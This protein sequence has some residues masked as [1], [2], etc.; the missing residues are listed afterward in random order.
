MNRCLF[1]NCD[2]IFNASTRR[3]TIKDKLRQ[4]YCKDCVERSFYDD[5]KIK[6]LDN[7]G[8]ADK[9]IERIYEFN[10]VFSEK[11]NINLIDDKINPIIHWNPR[12]IRSDS[13]Q[14]YSVYGIA[15]IMEQDITIYIRRSNSEERLLETF[16]HELVHLVMFYNFNESIV[17]LD[18]HIKMFWKYLFDFGEYIGF[19]IPVGD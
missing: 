8:G 12:K 9:I 13:K 19:E 10:K 15:D 6:V 7:Y 4:V 1:K 5:G 16:I 17:H 11:Y 18:G 14:Y 2:N 3:R